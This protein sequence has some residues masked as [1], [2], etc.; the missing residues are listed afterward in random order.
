M[1]KCELDNGL[2]LN[3]NNK[4]DH[5]VR[6]EV[7]SK[8]LH[9]SNNDWFEDSSWG[10]ELYAASFIVQ[11]ETKKDKINRKKIDRQSYK[12]KIERIMVIKEIVD[13]QT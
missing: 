8:S 10:K 5:L 3:P 9:Q 13:K 6:T 1:A 7:W 4:F 12:G 2:E 11:R